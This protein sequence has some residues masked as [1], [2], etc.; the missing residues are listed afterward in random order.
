MD[1]EST[2]ERLIDLSEVRRLVPVSRVTIWAWRRQGQFPSPV[3]LPGS[4]RVVWRARDVRKWITDR[5][6][7][8]EGSF[9]RKGAAI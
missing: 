4:R 8:S 9:E 6:D 1:R 7:R 3:R 2:D 5:P